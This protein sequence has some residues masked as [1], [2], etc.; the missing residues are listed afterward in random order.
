MTGPYNR[1]LYLTTLGILPHCVNSL[2]RG[3][4]E[5]RMKLDFTQSH[6]HQSPHTAI[7]LKED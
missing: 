4:F 3:A 5:N 6:A 7:R 1:V 2:N